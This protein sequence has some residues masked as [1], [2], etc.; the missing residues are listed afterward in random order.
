VV[1]K[2]TKQS[3]TS[4]S[5]PPSITAKRPLSKKRIYPA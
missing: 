3:A 2:L 1:A 5:A 4:A